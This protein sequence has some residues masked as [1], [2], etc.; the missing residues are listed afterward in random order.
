MAPLKEKRWNL[1]A[2][3]ALLVAVILAMTG[4]SQLNFRSQKRSDSL[5]LSSAPRHEVLHPHQQAVDGWSSLRSP[6]WG[7]KSC[8]WMPAAPIRPV[9]E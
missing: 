7:R 2:A 6:P 3:V 5:T 4:I 8:A 9:T 1:L